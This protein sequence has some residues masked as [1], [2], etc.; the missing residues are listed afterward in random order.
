MPGRVKN[1]LLVPLASAIF[2]YA[3]PIKHIM[4]I[5]N[6]MFIRGLLQD[7]VWLWW[8]MNAGLWTIETSGTWINWCSTFKS[9][10]KFMLVFTHYPKVPALV[11]ELRQAAMIQ[12]ISCGISGDR[13]KRTW[14]GLQAFVADVVKIYKSMSL[15]SCCFPPTVLS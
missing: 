6:C 9:E 14:A 15:V 5:L 4:T 3:K 13:N 10:N 11:E 12:E 1:I 2:E 8:T 7:A